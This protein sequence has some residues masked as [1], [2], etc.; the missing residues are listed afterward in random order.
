[1]ILCDTNI[2]F[3]IFRGNSI[4]IDELE[5]IGYENLAIC[6]VTIG[7]IYFGMRKGEENKLKHLFDNLIGTILPKMLQKYLYK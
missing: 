7:E 2:I 4:V 1:M 5:K 6:D 3:E